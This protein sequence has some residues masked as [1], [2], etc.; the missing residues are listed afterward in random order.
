MWT[1]FQGWPEVAVF[2]KD[3]NAEMVISKLR[4]FF[5]QTGVPTKFRSDGGLQFAAASTRQFLKELGSESGVFCTS[6]PI[7][8]RIGR[9]SSEITE[10]PRPHHPPPT[11]TSTATH[12]CKDSWNS[13]THHDQMDS[14]LLKSS[15]ADP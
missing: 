15:T 1:A 14:H 9:I 12:S 10:G 13:G 4:Q 6:F 3:P 11:E 5:A 2:N 8:Q 7:I